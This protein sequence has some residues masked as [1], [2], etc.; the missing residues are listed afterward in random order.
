MDWIQ[1]LFRIFVPAI[2]LGAALGRI[3][4]RRPYYFRSI[5]PSLWWPLLKKAKKTRILAIAVFSA[6]LAVALLFLNG[7]MTTYL[8]EKQIPLVEPREY[9]LTAKKIPVFLLFPLV[10]LFAILEEWLFRAILLEEFSICLRSRTAGLIISSVVFGI[11]HLSNPGTYPAFVLPLIIAGLILGAAYLFRGFSCA[12][13]THCFYNSM[14][15]I[16]Q[17]MT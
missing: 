6:T 8:E 7:W 5:L 11:F 10:N 3:I 12:V 17:L 1:P 15:V 16:L 13:L 9:P 14:L 2:L 4:A